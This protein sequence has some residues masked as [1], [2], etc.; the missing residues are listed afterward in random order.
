M[1]YFLKA[2]LKLF[3]LMS[4][5]LLVLPQ[6]GWSQFGSG[7]QGTILDPSLAVI[8]DARVIVVNV[9]TGVTREALSNPEG[10]YRI[11]G[12]GAGTYTVKASKAGFNTAEQPSVVLAQKP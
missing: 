11:F 10:V 6:P 9:S 5:T 3:L 12:I 2:S 8:P 7:I 1:N 4:F